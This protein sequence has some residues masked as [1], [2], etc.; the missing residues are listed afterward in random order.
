MA[1]KNSVRYDRELGA[2]V[3]RLPGQD[4]DFLLDAA[5]RRVEQRG[6]SAGG[7]GQEGLGGRGQD[8]GFLP[9]ATARLLYGI[10]GALALASGG[11]PLACTCQ[12]ALSLVPPAPIPRCAA[13]HPTRFTCCTATPPPH[14][15]TS[16]ALTRPPIAGGAPQ[17]HL[18]IT[19]TGL[20]NQP[21]PPLPPPPQVVR[22]NDTS[23]K[24]INEWTGEK[25]LR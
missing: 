24:S 19:L 5:V 22:R 21:H 8:A 23:A 13:L 17:R 2:F 20:T 7:V 16:P 12:A 18:Y 1:P 3:V 11:P 6:S 9:D 15:P 10:G 4:A 25:M 14:Q